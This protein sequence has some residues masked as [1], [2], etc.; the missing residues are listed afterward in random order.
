[1]QYTSHKID[2]RGVE[3]SY[4]IIEYKKSKQSN[5][6]LCFLLD[7]ASSEVQMSSFT[8][9]GGVS[10]SSGCLMY[11]LKARNALEK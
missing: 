1:M 7:Q 10:S 8:T 4:D 3:Y 5:R 11:R 2:T 9:S 6:L